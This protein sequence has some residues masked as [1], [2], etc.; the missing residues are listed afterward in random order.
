MPCNSCLPCWPVK[1]SAVQKT[2]FVQF[3]EGTRETWD[4][5]G[6]LVSQEG[7]ELPMITLIRTWCSS[8]EG[9]AEF[10]RMATTKP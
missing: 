2:I 8:G 5:R 1:E 9:F 7:D 6:I 10:A 3:I 4:Y